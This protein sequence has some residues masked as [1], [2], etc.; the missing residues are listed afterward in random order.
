MNIISKFVFL[1]ILLSNAFSIYAQDKKIAPALSHPLKFGLENSQSK[2]RDYYNG[3][4]SV[5]VVAILVQFQEDDDNRSTGNGLFDLSNKYLNPN[6][7]RDTVVD[8]PPYD[9]AY[10]VD[11][12]MFLQNYYN[13]SSKG[14]LKINFDLYGTVINMPNKME[15]YS[16]QRNENNAKLGNLYQDAWSRADAFID[17]SQYQNQKVAYVIFH[18]G[19]GR[20]VDLTSVFGFDPTPYDIPSVFIG[21]KNLR[22]FFGNNYNGYQTSDGVLIQNSLIIPSTEI[23]ELDLISGR[24]LLELGMNGILTAS[25]GSYLGLPDL[26][27]TSNGKTAIGRFGLMDGQSLF[28]YNGIF[29]PEP[30]AWEKIYLGWVKPVTISYGTENIKL[31]AVSK[32]VERDSAIYKVLISSQ[33]YFLIENRNRDPEGDGQRIYSR[34]RTF[35]D[36]TLYQYDDLDGFY[37]SGGYASLYKINGN[38]RDVQTFDWS[39][40]GLIDADDSYKG[41]ILIWHIDET[42]INANLLSNTVNNNIDRRGVDLEE[43]KGA[44][45]IG[46][47]FSTPFGNVTGDGTIVDYWF[48]GYHSVPDNIYQNQFTPNSIPS[49]LSY[50]LSNN[51]IYIK[52]FSVMDTLM[53]ANVSIGSATLSPLAGF[54]KKMSS[55]TN[56]IS[57]AIAFDFTGDASEELFANDGTDIYGFSDSGQPLR[58]SGIVVNGYGDFIPALLDDGQKYIIGVNDNSV[59]FVNSAFAQQQVILPGTSVASAPVLVFSPDGFIYAGRDNGS[60][61]K[62]SNALVPQRLDSLSGKINQFARSRT[63]DYGTAFGTT[64][65]AI[66]GALVNK[67]STDLLTINTGN[68]IFINGSKV[69][70]AYQIGEID[71]PPTLADLDSDGKQEIIFSSGGKVYAINATGVLIDNFPA[72]ISGEVKSGI[73]VCDVNADEIYDLI[74]V[75]TDG[76]LYAYSADGKI[77]SN[78]PIKIG[79]GT[80]STPALANFND[81]LGIAVAGGDGFLYGFKTNI[82]YSSANVLW[83]NYQKDQYLSNNNF[84]TGSNPVTFSEKLPSGRVY[85]WP[86][87][88][89]DGTTFIRYYLNGN[90]TSVSIRI[91]DL[92]GELVT[93]LNGTAI[94]NADNEVRWNV[95]DVQSG[96]YYGVISAEIDGASEEK[97]IKI[98]IVK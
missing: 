6:T 91:L 9:S 16:P 77:V 31:P 2:E 37:Y 83:K 22:E 68:E 46:V 63:N 18:A 36:S 40:P 97:I 70:I 39:L 28:S 50:S 95:S 17:F 49:S 45:E 38:V 14:K 64:K 75:T 69:N 78:F 58:D 7:G 51:N 82:K 23:R 87:P 56:N 35:T 30:S 47:T 52:N 80:Y 81:T 90:A 98:A 15:A 27:N 3:V 72:R 59:N 65:Y 67:T 54:P 55:D 94:S 26:F 60:I 86:N 32:F 96:I 92:S 73:S 66:Y 29:P 57:Q 4:D 84:V 42:V 71:S 11:H 13:K 1:L 76:D 12:L 10:F 8:A 5:K 74:F 19:V 93:T 33:E 85:N 25:F 79:A 48:N 62:L 88:V 20:D 41:G 43:A 89:Y 24:F 53:T 21:L 34:N 61:Y 44:Q